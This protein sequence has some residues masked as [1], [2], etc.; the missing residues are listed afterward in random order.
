MEQEVTH[1][2]TQAK[3]HGLET[4]TGDKQ[5]WKRDKLERQR[6]KTQNR[7]TRVHDWGD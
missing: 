7:Q 3:T 5:T 4:G 2:E 1:N 6:S